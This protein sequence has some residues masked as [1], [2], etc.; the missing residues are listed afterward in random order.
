MRGVLFASRRSTYYK[1]GHEGIKNGINQGNA[2]NKI[3]DKENF[4]EQGLPKRKEIFI[5]AVGKM[6]DQNM[7]NF[8]LEEKP[9]ELK[10]KNKEE[11]RKIRLTMLM[12]MPGNC[13]Q[14]DHCIWSSVMQFGKGTGYA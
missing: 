14:W 9:Q 13:C 11:K 1:L 6:I 2:T 4:I 10:T 7:F 5:E 3:F 12:N 8:K